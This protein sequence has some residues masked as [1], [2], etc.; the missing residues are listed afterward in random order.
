MTKTPSL[1]VEEGEIVRYVCETD[2]AC[3][4]SPSI[5]WFVDDD[6]VDFNDEHSVVN[7]P[8]PGDYNG[9]KTKNILILT[10]KR[11]MNMKKVKCVL[12]NDAKKFVE[13]NMNVTCKYVI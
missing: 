5:L 9:Q 4:D 2:S 11:E 8:S 13:H 12:E 10:T 7:D 6:P 1:P 3:P